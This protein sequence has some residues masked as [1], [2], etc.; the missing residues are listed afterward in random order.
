MSRVCE[1]GELL[2]NNIYIYLWMGDSGI[3]RI[4]ALVPPVNIKVGFSLDCIYLPL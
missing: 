4:W 1:F 2:S 3:S